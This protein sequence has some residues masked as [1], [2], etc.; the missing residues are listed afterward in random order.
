M[1]QP[2]PVCPSSA[3]LIQRICQFNPKSNGLIHPPLWKGYWYDPLS[4]SGFVLMKDPANGSEWF[5]PS[6]PADR[7]VWTDLPVSLWVKGKV[8]TPQLTVSVHSVV[9][10]E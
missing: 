1:W 8:Y 3:P 4:Q 5:L 7:P 2:L 6:T 9:P 10:P